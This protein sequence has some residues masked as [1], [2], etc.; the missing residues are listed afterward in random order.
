MDNGGGNENKYYTFRRKYYHK[1]IFIL[2]V[3][4]ITLLIIG[5]I[6][7]ACFLS[8]PDKLCQSNECLRTATML[9]QNMDFTVDPCEDFFKFTCGNFDEE[10]PRPDSQTSHD[11]FTERQGKVLRQ[12][13]K[14]LQMKTLKNQSSTDPYPV[15][16]ARWLYESC[17][18]NV[19]ADNLQYSSLFKYLNDYN[20]PKIPALIAKPNDT[21]FKF[22]WIKSIV[23]IKKSLGTDTLIGFEIFPDPKNRSMKFLAIGSPSQEDELPLIDDTLSKRMKRMK[24]KWSKASEETPDES[25][26]TISDSELF[27]V[28]YSSYM[29]D[30][31]SML[32]LN[33]DPS[34]KLEENQKQIIKAMESTIY[35]SQQVY[36][37]IDQ[38]ENYSKNEE[39]RSGLTDLIY[40]KISDIQNAT[41]LHITPKKPFPVFE[42]FLKL[43]LDGIPEAHF[44]YDSDL[45]L[46]SNADLLYLKLAIQ[47][48]SETSEIE[49]EMF[50]WWC[51]VEDLIL[52]TTNDV[53]KLYYEYS[54]A[55]TQIEGSQSRSAY[56]TSTVNKLMGMAVSYLIVEPDF[57]VSIKPKVETMVANIQKSFKTLV[58][59][60]TWMDWETKK[61]TLEKTD[62]MVSLIGFP[63]WIINKT[64]L[65]RHYKGIKINSTT[66]LD[67]IV[68]LLSWQFMEKLS[69][70]RMPNEFEWATSPS[71]VNAFHTFQANAITIPLA[72]LQYP[73]YHLGLEALNYGSIGSILGHELTHGFDDI[74]RQFDKEGNK[75]QWWTNRTVEEYVNKTECFI[76]QYS[77]YYLPEVSEY[78]NGELTLGENIADNGGLREAFYAYNY[79]VQTFGKEAK[80]PGFE[81]YNAEQLFF[82]SFGNL[83]CESITPSGLRFALEDS[84]CPG[85]I[86]LLGVLSNS[87]EFSNAFNCHVGQA[88][89][90]TDDQ[91]CVI[92]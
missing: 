50:L 36:R 63:E 31:V 79:Y 29:K 37:F 68:G 77:G 92:W 81:S 32:I 8:F 87:R 76:K 46:T 69:N 2:L 12:I 45:V 34:F 23:K 35:I 44:D 84:H 83:W 59:H 58:R 33:G 20:L 66:F 6:V 51:V 91:K 56:C 42:K 30:V 88:M 73:F 75:I 41:D 22:D 53:R 10:H 89:H 55:I 80:L 38:A 61:S 17:L 15:E 25:G 19:A 9:Q 65:E 4:I 62:K 64:L 57:A 39:D 13:R 54:R 1:S 3:L 86:R 11:W 7:M 48:I 70:W 67:N 71:N 85:K 74:G 40:L 24:R 72:I 16:Q 47:L 52:Y 90:R 49:L 5:I 82:I 27:L 78:I 26:E 14:K 21:N 60:T 18:D 43:L 28:S